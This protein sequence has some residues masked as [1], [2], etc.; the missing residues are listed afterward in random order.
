MSGELDSVSPRK[1]FGSEAPPLQIPSLRWPP[2]SWE[3]TLTR[4]CVLRSGFPCFC[5]TS[6][7]HQNPQIWGWV[8]PMGQKPAWI[9]ACPPCSAASW[10]S[11]NC[12]WQGLDV[13]HILP[14]LPLPCQIHIYIYICWSLNAHC[15]S[16][17]PY[18]DIRC[19]VD[20]FKVRC[21]HQK[22]PSL[23]AAQDNDRRRGQNQ[24]TSSQGTLNTAGNTRN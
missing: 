9:C 8:S 7:V 20:V 6:L 17:W 23:R 2:C 5:L 11:F 13:S 4:P 14:S 10:I 1:G 18:S 22:Y 19:F 3:L 24:I 21:H 15:L 16:M 12:L